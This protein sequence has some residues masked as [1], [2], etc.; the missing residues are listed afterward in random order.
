[1]SRSSRSVVELELS[2]IDNTMWRIL[3]VNHA[4]P[5][6]IEMWAE[7]SWLPSVDLDECRQHAIDSIFLSKL[8][9][10]GTTWAMLLFN[11]PC[12]GKYRCKEPND[13]RVK[14]HGLPMDCSRHENHKAMLWNYHHTIGR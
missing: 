1:M 5:I 8:H 4:P 10:M 14:I 2:T 7:W 9:V 6:S 3:N 11:T 12:S 13:V